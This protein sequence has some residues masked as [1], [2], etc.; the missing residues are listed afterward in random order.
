MVELDTNDQLSFVGRIDFQFQSGGE[1]VC[2]EVIE[3][4]ILKSGLVKQAMV[5]AMPDDNLG[6]VPIAV[7]DTDQ[8][9]DEI[10]QFI[11][12]QLPVYLQPKS[13]VL[14]PKAL[15]DGDG[16]DRLTMASHIF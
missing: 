4:A 10:R 3:S 9:F 12:N 16:C 6:Q 1:T 2:P 14:W 8:S 5:I 15:Q 11:V 7:V 13:W